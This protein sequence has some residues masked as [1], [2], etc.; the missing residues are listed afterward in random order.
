MAFGYCLFSTLS[1]SVAWENSSPNRACPP[2]EV[3]RARGTGDTYL[4]RHVFYQ[5]KIKETHD[6]FEL[7]Y[8]WPKGSGWTGDG[9]PPEVRFT[10][11][12][13]RGTNL[14]SKK[15]SN[16]SVEASSTVSEC[17]LVMLVVRRQTTSYALA[18]VYANK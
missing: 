17:L 2:S 8:F 13:G 9:P 14:R 4:F 11:A 18:I 1:S 5:K 7:D 15:D 6:I 12:G 10:D 3:H 16:V